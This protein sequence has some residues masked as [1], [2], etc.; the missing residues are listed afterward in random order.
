MGMRIRQV[1]AAA[2]LALWSAALWAGTTQSFT[3]QKKTYAGSRDRQYKIYIPA[4]AASPAPMV[5]VLHGCQQTHDDVLQ[6]WGLTAAADRFGFI[7]VAPFITSYDGVRN[8][9]CWGFWLDGHRHQGRGEVE[10]L[11]RLAREVESRLDVDPQRRYI[12]GLSSGAAMAVV[13]ATAHNEYW[14]A[15][16]SAAGLP[17]GEDAASVSFSGCPGS[18]SFHSLA[19]VLGDMRAERNSTYAIP[20]MVLQNDRDCTVTRPAGRLLRDAQ[21]KLAGDDAHDTPDE[22]RAAEQPCVPVFGTD[23]SCRHVLYTADGSTTSRSLVET[24]FYD[25]PAATPNGS[26]TDHGHYWIGGQHGRNGK[27]SLQKGPSY[28]DIIWDFFARHPRPAGAGG[29]PDPVPP[30]RRCGKI[31]A[32]PGNHISQGRAAAGGWL[33][34]RAIASGDGRD[35]GSAWDFWFAVTLHEGEPGR[36]YASVPA[37]CPR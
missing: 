16:A 17:Y 5:M 18:A 23:Y 25:G 11:H 9:N 32:S 2:L 26:D 30:T 8:A 19:R 3:F 24:V 31:A 21:L 1:A 13:A 12:A 6:D 34:W 29:G 22:A 36:W 4:N 20:L 14:S 33:N 37:G 27:W 10:D 28:P 15:A 7:L 35:I